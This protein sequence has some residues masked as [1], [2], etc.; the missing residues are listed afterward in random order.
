MGKKKISDEE[1][2]NPKCDNWSQTACV[3]NITITSKTCFTNAKKA[4]ALFNSE[5]NFPSSD[6]LKQIW[7]VV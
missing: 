7:E 4:K 5:E 3:G 2:Q 1:A 6:I